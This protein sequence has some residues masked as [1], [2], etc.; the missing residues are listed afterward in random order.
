MF[1]SAQSRMLSARL[2]PK[3][4]AISVLAAQCRPGVTSSRWLSTAADASGTTSTATS[5]TISPD[6]YY[7]GQVIS[8]ESNKGYGRLLVSGLIL[9][10]PVLVHRS[11]IV[12][13]IP[14]EKLPLRFPYLRPAERV[15]FQ[16]QQTGDR[17]EAKRVVFSRTGK[18]IPAVRKNFFV[19]RQ[20]RDEMFVGKG[21]MKIYNDA[22]LN[23]EQKAA[24]VKELA[25]TIIQAYH[26]EE[27][28]LKS[29]GLNPDDYREDPKEKNKVRI[30]EKR[31]QRPN[32]PTKDSSSSSSSRSSS[33]GDGDGD[34]STQS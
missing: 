3:L 11:E 26:A 19:G 1:L 15:K 23:E 28:L 6:T 13:D 21:V 5:I 16:I 31:Q 32:T 24:A 29:L 10:R 27:E 14:L 18:A 33:L 8:Y 4:S 30:R 7:E 2:C 17:Y 12:T 9:P 22:N 34:S 25:T 20:L